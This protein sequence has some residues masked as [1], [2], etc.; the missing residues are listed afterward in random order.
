MPY[1]DCGP[2]EIEIQCS[3]DGKKYRTL[4]RATVQPNKELVVPLDEVQSAHFRVVF[5]SSH[6]FRGQ[7]NWNVQVAE[8]ALLTRAELKNPRS[9]RKGM[10]QRDAMVDLTESI[11]DEGHL[12]DP[13]D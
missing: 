10:W 12:S 13:N 3:D 4:R 8:I 9:A 1:R 5:L 2:K 6:P 11:D 7:E